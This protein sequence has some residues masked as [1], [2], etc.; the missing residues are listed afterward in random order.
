[1][2]RTV[3]MKVTGLGSTV[4]A[5]GAESALCGMPGVSSASANAVTGIVTVEYDDHQVNEAVISKWIGKAGLKPAGEEYSHAAARDKF[6]ADLKERVAVAWLSAVVVCLTS[7]C[8]EDAWLL[9]IVSAIA[10]LPAMAY[11]GSVFFLNTIRQIRLGGFSADAP[12][13]L[14]SAFAYLIS[15]TGVLFPSF[16]LDNY[17][18]PPF[19]FNAAALIIAFAATARLYE[20]KSMR[21]YEMAASA[22]AAMIPKQAQSVSEDGEKAMPA[23]SLMRGDRIRVNPDERFAADGRIIE[24]ETYADESI[25]VEDASDVFK[26]TGDKVFAG[27]KNCGGTVV[28]EA[29]TIGSDTVLMRLVEMLRNAQGSKAPSQKTAGKIISVFVPVVLALSL[30][31]FAAWLNAYD[32]Y[33]ISRGMTVFL[34][35]MAVVCMSAFCTVSPFSFAATVSRGAWSHIFF[36]GAAALETMSKADVVVLDDVWA[37]VLSKPYV[38]EKYLSEKCTASDL[39]AL[40]GLKKNSDTHILCAA[41]EYVKQ[42]LTEAGKEVEENDNRGSCISAERDA[43]AMTACNSPGSGE[44]WVGDA[45]SAKKNGAEDA[46][47]NVVFSDITEDCEIVYFGKGNDVLAAFAVKGKVK[48]TAKNAVRKLRARGKRVV[49]LSDGSGKIS[50]ALGKELGADKAIA[51]TSHDEK[52]GFLND[53]KKRG[54]TVALVSGAEDKAKPEEADVYVT[55]NNEPSAAVFPA[56]VVLASG[57]LACLAKAFSLSQETVSLIRRNVNLAAVYNV[58]GILAASGALHS[59]FNSILSPAMAAAASMCFA[60][61]AVHSCRSLS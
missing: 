37:Y 23:A 6:Y 43:Q 42:M 52:V 54:N 18:W 9:G 58:A 14:S 28:V 41:Y 11:G 25:L 21:K 35:V 32:I 7:V 33:S 53:L 49:L 57:N 29:E 31:S 2:I 34:A 24:G 26:G 17:G 30:L 50:P 4:A 59:V 19:Y 10:A 16:W 27:T 12:V 38:V 3:A 44:Y 56:D 45:L 36:K 5:F 51:I 48:K 61:F 20:E 13:A 46:C 1:M 22:L 47:R 55:I 15:L 39:S 60:V 8:T 40:Y